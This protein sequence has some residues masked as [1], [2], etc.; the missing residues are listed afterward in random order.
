MHDSVTFLL[1]L[2][3]WALLHSLSMSQALKRA[4]MGSLGERYA[5]YR[6]G[7]TVFSVVSFGVALLLLPRMPQELYRVPGALAW[8]FWL[9]R[10]AAAAFFVWTFKAFDI[11]E[12]SGVSQARTYPRGIIGEDGEFKGSHGLAISGA[13]R[14]MRHPMYFA[15]SVYLL[16]DP[17]MT[18][19]QFL[20]AV[21]VTAYGLIGSVFE[22]RRL[23]EKFGEDYRWYQKEVPRFIPRFSATDDPR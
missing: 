20:F 11:W 17:V 5:F 19:E 14:Y 3:V 13:Y 7:F 16:A 2:S 8:V 21:F 6:L 4:L 9:V 23:V 22:E 10:I 1:I 15:S 18:W 12:F